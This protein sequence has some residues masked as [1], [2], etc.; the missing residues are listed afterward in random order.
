MIALLALFIT[1]NTTC[2]KYGLTKGKRKHDIIQF[3]IIVL[4]IFDPKTK[5][6]LSKGLKKLRGVADVLQRG[7][8]SAFA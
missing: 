7:F 1:L 8:I 3:L 4:L 2:F 6:T 5:F